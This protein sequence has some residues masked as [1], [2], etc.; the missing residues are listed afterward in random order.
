MP[1]ASRT[2][3]KIKPV[4][5]CQ[6]SIVRKAAGFTLIELLVVIVIIGILVTI[7]VASYSSAQQ[8]ARDARRKSDFDALKKALT[9]FYSDYQRY[10]RRNE[11]GTDCDWS[12]DVYTCWANLLGPDTTSYIKEV[13]RDPRNEDLGNCELNGQNC[14]IYRYCYLSDDSY[15]L[16]ANLE[17]PND[18]DIKPPTN[19]IHGGPKRY[20]ITNP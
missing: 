17:N 9:L 11:S 20:W 13:P 8:R 18:P 2:F 15:I 10:P 4:V 6:L 3:N 7:G 19:C 5:N 14:Y 1:H 12:S 16:I